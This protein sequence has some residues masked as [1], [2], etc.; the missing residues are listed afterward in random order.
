LVKIVAD[1][2]VII[3]LYSFGGPK[4]FFVGRYDPGGSPHM[5]SLLFTPWRISLK[6]S[7]MIGDKE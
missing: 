7:L 2:Q 5:E 6:C 1:I 3:S 4:V